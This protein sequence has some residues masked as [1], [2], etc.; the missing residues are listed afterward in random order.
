MDNVNHQAPSDV[1]DS[2]MSA[3]WSEP[4]VYREGLFDGAV[5]L[6]SGGGSGIGRA[7]ALLLARLGAHVVICGRTQEKL[8]R[9]AAFARDRGARVLPIATNVRDPEQVAQLFDRITKDCGPL[10]GVVNNAGGQFPQPAIDFSVKGWNA[11]IDSN[12]NGTWHMMQAAARYWRD[13][14][15]RGSLVNLVAV[16]DRGIPGIAHSMAARAGVIGVTRTVAVEWAPYGIRVNCIAPGLTASEGL[17]VYPPEARRA[18]HRANPLRRPG[19]LREIAESTVFLVSPASTFMTGEVMTVDGGG[20]LWGDLW[21]IERPDTCAITGSIHTPSMSQY[22]PVTAQEIADAA[23]EAANAGAAIVHLHARNPRDGRPDQSPEAFEPFLRDIKRRSNVVVNL[24][25][26]GSPFMPVEERIKPAAVWKPE[27][28]SLNMGSMNFGLFPMLKRFK[29][30]KHSWEPEMLENSRDLVFRNSF[31]DI[32]YALRTLNETGT[33]YEFEC[34]DTSHLYNL[35]HFW[36]EGLVQGPL[37][38]QTVFGLLGGIGAHPEDVQHMKRTADR[39]FGDN[40]RWSVLGAGRNQMPLVAASAA[41]GGN[42]RV[43]LED[44]LW[45][46]KGRIAESNAEQVRQARTIVEGL[47]LGIAS[48]DEAREILQLKG[49]DKVA[50]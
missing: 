16:V 31:K 12:L 27:V 38:I 21:T 25:T 46:G 20:R 1:H 28:A 14:G 9:V 45:A 37:F 17:E 24:T 7:I 5:V 3:L 18:F 2:A 40:Y 48:P 34:Y 22:L 41:Q 49:I 43:G 47:G 29:N 35:H 8:D 32:E 6:V 33:R 10:T 42:V 19:S 15:Q 50:F 23:V 13:R 36:Q 44:S 4:T 39:L 30:F 11:F 26:G